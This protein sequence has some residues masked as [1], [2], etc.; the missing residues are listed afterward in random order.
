MKKIVYVS[1]SHTSAGKKKKQ[2]QK[3][4][5]QTRKN[6]KHVPRVDQTYHQVEYHHQQWVSDQKSHP[7]DED[8]VTD[9]HS[10]VA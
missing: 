3:N 7:W 5:F 9:H 10:V 6:V 8:P 1:M 4:N 2:F